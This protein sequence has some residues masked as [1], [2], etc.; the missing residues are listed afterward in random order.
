MKDAIRKERKA[1][2]H[3]VFVDDASQK[4]MVEDMIPKPKVGFK[5]KK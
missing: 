2:I 1:P 5:E 4:K 3:E